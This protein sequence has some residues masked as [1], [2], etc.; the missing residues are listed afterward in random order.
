MVKVSHTYMELTLPIS[1]LYTVSICP[2]IGELLLLLDSSLG[3]SVLSV[4]VCSV[5]YVPG[6]EHGSFIKHPREWEERQLQGSTGPACLKQHLSKLAES[7]GLH[8]SVCT[9][10][11]RDEKL[12]DS[13]V[14]VLTF[15]NRN[16]NT[17]QMP[18]E[19]PHAY[20]R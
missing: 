20:H 8:V 10:R 7:R 19:L 16:T 1:L 14:E 3:N 15:R 2:N 9:L 13:Q 4:C 12:E 5:C 18:L 17:A 6:I 11:G